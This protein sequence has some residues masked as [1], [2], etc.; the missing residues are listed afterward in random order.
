MYLGDCLFVFCL[1]WLILFLFL[2]L[3]KSLLIRER[4]TV[5]DWWVGIADGEVKQ[6]LLIRLGLNHPYP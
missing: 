1:W 3:V 6:L 4:L 2:F 5:S